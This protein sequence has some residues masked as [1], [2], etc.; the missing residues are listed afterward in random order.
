MFYV[1]T[2]Q[3]FLDYPDY[4]QQEYSQS[5]YANQVKYESGDEEKF[6]PSEQGNGSYE[7]RRDY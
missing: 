1:S 7:Y 4:S 5:Q 6:R 2:F 3:Y